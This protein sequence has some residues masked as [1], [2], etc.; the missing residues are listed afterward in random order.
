MALARANS[1]QEALLWAL[2]DL[3]E[4]SFKTLKFHLRDV[5]Q[6]H[7]ARGELEGL[8]QVDLASKLISMYGAQEA[9]RVVGRSLQAMNLM[10]LVDYLN[11]VCLNDYREIYREHV[12]CLEERQD[13]G[14]NSSHNKLLLVAT[15]SSGSLRSP[16]CSDLEQELDPVHVETLFA[17]EAESYST[18]PIVVMQGSAGTGKTTLVKKLVQ[19]WA[20][21]KLYPGQ[22]DYVFYVSCREVVLLP[23]CDLPNL[24]CWCCGDDQAPVTEILRQPER[25][26]FILDGYD[27]LQKSSR[28]ERV[29][30]ILMRRREVPCSLLI[31]TRPPALQS[32]EPML[33]ERRHVHVLGFS[34]E[35]RET[36]FCSYFMDKEQLRNALEFVQNNAVLYKACQVPG[37]CW[38]VCSWLKGK[39]ARGQEVSETPSN[40][41]D[42]FT[43]YVSTFLPTD[44]NGDSSELTRHK[45]LRGLCSLAAEGMRHQ[46]LLFEEDVL[47][48]HSLDGPSLTAFLNCTDYREGL[49]IKKLYSFCHIS[50]QEFFY[51]MSFLVKE[52]QGQLGEATHKEVAKLV[53]QE[54]YEEVTLSLQFL[55]DMLK[56]DNTLSLGLKFCF[57]IA[58]SVRQDL[59]HFKEQV[60]AIKYNRSW[61]LEFSLYDSK[62]KK[63]KQGIQMKDVIFN[64]QHSDEK[65]SGKKKPFSVT[66]RFGKGPILETGKSTRKQK[67]ASNGKSRETEEPPAQDG[68]KSRLASRG[69]GNKEI[70]DKDGGVYGQEDG[71]GQEV[72]KGGEILDEMNG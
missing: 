12:L 59:K 7:L 26:L 4:N 41:T 66:S 11:Q 34:E 38:V 69:K 36:Y 30:H 71:E 18:P 29:L 33:G 56:T 21:G 3:E 67:K 20:K 2:N 24:I 54:N 5:T 70:N 46:R 22:F 13:W 9:V 42:I 6:F 17:P 31:T 63:L 39:M 61:D 32:L 28:A 57:K 52:D 49:G 14:V 1:P 68:G 8:S 40:S 45:V 16:S 44:G 47:R 37:I 64:V 51:A 48:K 60:V 53:D 19:D 35:E 72:K 25:L 23:K 55:F 65:K 27:E 58:P 43:A 15:S 62:I 50:F 10:E